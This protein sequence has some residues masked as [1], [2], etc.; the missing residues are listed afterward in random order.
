[1]RSRGFYFMDKLKMQYWRNWCYARKNIYNLREKL[2]W[3]NRSDQPTKSDKKFR[4]SIHK[5]VIER[6]VQHFTDQ[7]EKHFHCAAEA[8]ELDL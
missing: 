6:V 3:D 7:F 2:G 8:T 4:I 5:L 1:L